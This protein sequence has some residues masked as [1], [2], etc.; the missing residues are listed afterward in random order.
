MMILHKTFLVFPASALPRISFLVELENYYA[1]ASYFC[2]VVSDAFLGALLGRG[3]DRK[4]LLLGISF[5]FI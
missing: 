2:V 4:L 1:F 3:G 5:V